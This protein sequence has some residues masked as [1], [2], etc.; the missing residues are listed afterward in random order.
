MK[1]RRQLI[2]IATAFIGLPALVRAQSLEQ[3]G[4]VRR[5]VSSFRVQPWQDHFDDLK[6]GAI[7][8]D[9]DSRAVQY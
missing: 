2:S 9:I 3:S 8:C 5:N 7:L 1:N 4:P 6:H